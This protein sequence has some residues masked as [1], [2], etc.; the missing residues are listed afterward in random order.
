MS[1]KD[2]KS[3]NEIDSEQLSELELTLTVLWNSVRRWMNQ[4]SNSSSITGLS[5]MDVFLL[6]LLV[7]RNRQLRGIDLAFALSIEDMHLVSYSLK[8]L[9]RLGLASSEKMGKEVFYSATEMGKE[10]YNDFQ[11]DRKK[12]LEPALGFISHPDYDLP[13]LN[14]VLRAYASAYEQAARTAASTKG[15]S[16]RK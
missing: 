8:K 12:F 10:H 2:K 6:H 4:R 16:D 11:N 1:F 3:S 5:D 14:N 15:P 7:Y 13:T 9:A